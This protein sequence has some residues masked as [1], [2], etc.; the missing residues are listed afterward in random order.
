VPSL[1]NIPGI[2]EFSGLSV[3]TPH[4]DDN[5]PLWNR[6]P[7][8]VRLT[9]GTIRVIQSPILNSTPGAWRFNASLTTLS[10]SSNRAAQ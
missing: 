5:M 4:F 10:G 6:I 2:S 1:L 7:L 3:A 9:D 8:E